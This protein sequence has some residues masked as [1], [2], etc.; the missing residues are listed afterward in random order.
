MVNYLRR[1]FPILGWITRYSES[2]SKQY[3]ASFVHALVSRLDMVDW[4]PYRWHYWSVICPPYA[5]HLHVLIKFPVALVGVPQ[6]MS[7]ALV[8]LLP[9][10]RSYSLT[11]Q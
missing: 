7:Y 9:F 5:S 8:F 11:A 2:L 10:A 1:L 6:S 4:R 3:L